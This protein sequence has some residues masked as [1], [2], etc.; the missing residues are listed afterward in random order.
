MTEIQQ[1]TGHTFNRGT[2]GLDPNWSQKQ[3]RATPF[4]WP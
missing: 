2:P 4:G 3:I 1:L